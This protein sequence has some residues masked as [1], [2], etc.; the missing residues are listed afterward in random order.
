VNTRQRRCKPSVSAFSPFS[1]QVRISC[2]EN[3]SAFRAAHP[4]TIEPDN[5]RWRNRVAARRADRVQCGENF[6]SIGLGCITNRTP[7]ARLYSSPPPL[8]QLLPRLDKLLDS[9]RCSKR[10]TIDNGALPICTL[11]KLPKTG[12]AE[13]CEVAGDFFQVFLRP[14]LFVLAEHQAEN[15]W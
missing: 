13:D 15:D 3:L 1:I 4:L 9:A 14:D 5:L 7:L 12:L 8:P 6:R 10:G 2:L 11:V